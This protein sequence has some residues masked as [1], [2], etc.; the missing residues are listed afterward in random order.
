[1]RLKAFSGITGTVI[2]CALSACDN[3]EF[4]GVQLE[5]V[6]PPEA[7]GDT[8]SQADS[9]SLSEAEP[10]IVLPEGPILYLGTRSGGRV[11]V[12]PVAEIAAGG[13]RS[14]DPER[15]PGFHEA[16]IERDLGPGSAFTLF[17]EGVRAGTMRVDEV[18]IDESGS[19]CRATPLA[20]GGAEF[21]P[22]AGTATRF[23]A[24]DQTVV[25]DLGY[26][27]YSPV[28]D[29]YE[30]RVAGIELANAALVRTGARW[31]PSVVETRADMQ[32]IPLDGDPTGAIAATFMYEDRLDTGE[33]DSD[34]AY[35]MMVFGTG[36][37][38]RY[39]L[40]YVWYRPVSD[41][42]KAAARFFE[43]FDWDG[44]GQAEILLEVLGVDTRWVAALDRG[45]EGWTSVF[46]TDCS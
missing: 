23:L 4:G 18:E 2:I 14:L 45:A 20:T 24:I 42:G 3:V 37:P 26:A 40:E 17:A 35:G 11:S 43:Q 32:A 19:F 36:G 1:M 15:T 31:P 25:G 10:V 44:D 28:D 41:G 46:E 9:T 38:E 6:P 5:L 12:R 33:P 39:S 16:L 8:L 30:Q 13:L 27:P 21:V 34:A 22:G 29:T 7:A